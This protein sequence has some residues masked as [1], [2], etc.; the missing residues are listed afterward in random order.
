MKKSKPKQKGMDWMEQIREKEKEKEKAF[1]GALKFL[2]ICLTLIILVT[3]FRLIVPRYGVYTL[4]GMRYV[5]FSRSKEG[6]GRLGWEK[7]AASLSHAL[8]QKRHR[9]WTKLQLLLV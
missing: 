7:K 4:C 3:S 2:F 5:G 8:I 1:W 9:F 6:V